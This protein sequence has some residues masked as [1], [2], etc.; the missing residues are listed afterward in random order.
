MLC[1]LARLNDGRHRVRVCDPPSTGYSAHSVTR[2]GCWC[3]HGCC[4]CCVRRG[5]LEISETVVYPSA[6]VK[7]SRWPG[8]GRY[9]GA[10]PPLWNCRAAAASASAMDTGS[11]APKP[12]SMLAMSTSVVEAMSRTSPC[13]MLAAPILKSAFMFWCFHTRATKKS[14]KIPVTILGVTPLPTLQPVPSSL[15]CAKSILIHAIAMAAMTRKTMA[16]PK[17]TKMPVRC[18][19]ITATAR[20]TLPVGPCSASLWPYTVANEETHTV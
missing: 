6:V 10:L 12:A 2:L 15:Q 3:C 9:I 5:A 4:C 8:G 11:T 19:I 14:T 17:V 13:T 18:F 7:R 16:T 1:T 20:S